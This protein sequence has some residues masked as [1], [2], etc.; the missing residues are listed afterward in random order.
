VAG[1]GDAVETMIVEADL[2]R[3]ASPSQSPRQAK[4]LGHG[5][6]S[7]KP[8]APVNRRR[9]AAGAPDRARRPSGTRETDPPSARHP[10]WRGLP[11]ADLGRG[12]T[13]RT[14]S[15]RWSTDSRPWAA[16]PAHT[17]GVRG[18]RSEPRRTPHR[19]LRPSASLSLADERRANKTETGRMREK[20][21]FP[22]SASS[23]EVMVIFARRPTIR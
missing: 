16:E 15:E 7:G 5:R 10:R 18:L 20:R 4:T 14:P 11:P 1:R 17:G 23:L 12:I 21:P 22:R 19:E 9:A 2:Q 8:R 6:E 13:R 3:P